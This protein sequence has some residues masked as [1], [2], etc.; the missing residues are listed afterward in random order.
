MARLNEPLVAPDGLEILRRKFLR[1]N[2]D[3]ARINSTQS[4]R[5]RGLENECARMLSENLELRSQILR[6]ETE[7]QESRAQRIADHALEIK[8][9]MEAQ[10]LEWGTMLASLGHE[11]IPKHRSPRATKKARRDPSLGLAGAGSPRFRRRNTSELE[12]AAINEGR[13]APLWE[14]RPYQRETLNRHEILALCS[15]AAETDSPD[16]GPPPVSRFVDE[17]PVKIDLPTKLSSDASRP[18]ARGE[19]LSK[20]PSR[21][22]PE[23]MPDT[24]KAKE[25]IMGRE[26]TAVLLSPP[27]IAVKLPAPDA[28][29]VNATLKRKIRDDEEK[30]NVPVMRMK[31]DPMKSAKTGPEKA[32]DRQTNRPIKNIP[33]S[34]KDLREN[35]QITTPSLAPRKAL[36]AKSTNEVIN[37]PKKSTKGTI[38]DDIAKAKAEMKGNEKPKEKAK[39][40][41]EEAIKPIEINIPEPTPAPAAII[42]I[43]T[44]TMSAEPN[45]SV[46]DSP[47]STAP[48]EEMRDT[49]P[50]AEISSRGETS[51]AGR[52]A[53]SQ[54]SY[55]EPNL[56]DKMRRPTKQLLDAVAGEGKA[57]RRTSQSK[58]NE[59]SSIKSEEKSSGWKSLPTMT[60]GDCE[61]LDD[62][63]ASPL[64]QKVSRALNSG[65][66]PSNT[67]ADRTNQD[68][69]ADVHKASFTN[70][71]VAK[72]MNKKLEEIA[73]REAEVAQLFD[74]PDVYEFTSTSPSGKRT[75]KAPST[76]DVKKSNSSR[77]G[78]SRRLSSILREDLG[79]ETHDKGR[80]ARKRAS[81]MVQ[82]TTSSL[83][84]DTSA[85]AD[86]DSSFNSNS[87][88]DT[89]VAG[90]RVS[91]RRRSMML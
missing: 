83:D 19:P 58:S 3:I 86:G 20:S 76:E 41:K 1:Q 10:L 12:A 32:A 6:L 68:T 28:Q 73:A 42:D 90:S 79:T 36:G 9:K 71:T 70:K 40:K 50:P 52:R 59:V 22:T 66:S 27:Q 25:D 46:P 34:K 89:E 61:K 60:A 81:M 88:G 45:L 48:R 33:L 64:A 77:N 2:R 53:R 65:D 15:E 85:T 21:T 80:G 69:S 54:V 55:A 75:S 91:M 78:K 5:I 84:G 74:G 14:D 8:E 56:R 30:E 87:S 24:A 16:I 82:K 4:L 35:N 7:L 72:G 29:I 18:E 23:P 62:V 51:R 39:P 49:P 37:S 44:D 31:G 38:L 47:E 26:K 17:D 63:A 43:D 13:L 57:M 11:P 67:L